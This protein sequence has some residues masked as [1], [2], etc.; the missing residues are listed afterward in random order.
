MAEK[1]VGAK[2]NKPTDTLRTVSSFVLKVSLYPI[3]LYAFRVYFCLD[4]ETFNSPN[5]SPPFTMHFITDAADCDAFY[6]S[7]TR[8]KYT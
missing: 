7:P 4:S 1:Y 2:S 5:V 8:D 6:R 3:W